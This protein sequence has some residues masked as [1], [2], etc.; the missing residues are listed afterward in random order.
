MSTMHAPLATDMGGMARGAR[1]LTLADNLYSLP[2]TAHTN[3]F[4]VT[5]VQYHW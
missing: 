5:R 1:T 4:V 2:A 3:L